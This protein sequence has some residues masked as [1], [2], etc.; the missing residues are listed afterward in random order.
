MNT[1]KDKYLNECIQYIL[2]TENEDFYENPST[3]HV[4]YSAYAYLY[5]TQLANDLIKKIIE[6]ENNE[7]N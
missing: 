6:E 5:G 1:D 7:N 3:N 2:D 4:Y